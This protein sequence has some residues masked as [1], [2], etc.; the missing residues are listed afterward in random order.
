MMH[1][2]DQIHKFQHSVATALLSGLPHAAGGALL[3]ELGWSGWWT[4]VVRRSLL[5]EAALKCGCSSLMTVF[6]F[7]TLIN[8]M[9]GEQLPHILERQAQALGIPT[10]NYSSSSTAGIPIPI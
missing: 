6:L 1:G 3:F 10:F 4:E 5:K 9:C 2:R 7:D 8:Q